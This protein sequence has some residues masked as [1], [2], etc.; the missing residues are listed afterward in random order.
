MSRLRPW[1]EL[2]RISNLPTV[3]TNVSVGT[4][5]GVAH[6]HDGFFR[7]NMFGWTCLSVSLL[8]IAGMILNDAVDAKI[9]A[10]ERPDRPIPS[11]RVS[12][13]AAFIAAGIGLALG[14]ASLA[15]HGGARCSGVWPSPWRSCC[16][17]SS[18][19]A[20]RGRSC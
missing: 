6:A 9:D 11:G 18:T 4:A 13:R 17:T 2:A 10:R 20:W 19:S 1:L 16:T 3:F 8:Y 12:R 5:V 14:V 7:W 15:P